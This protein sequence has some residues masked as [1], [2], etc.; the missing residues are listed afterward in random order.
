MK[1]SF[2][3]TNIT[4]KA[5]ENKIRTAFETD[6]FSARALC[7]DSKVLDR[8]SSEYVLDWFNNR[9]EK[10]PDS[11]QAAAIGSMNKNVEIVA[12]AGSGKTTA[13]VGRANF[14]INHCNVEPESI[15][16]LAFNREAVRTM[17]ERMEELSPDKSAIPHI[18]TFHSL[19]LSVVTS[20]AEAGKAVNDH[21]IV[22][23]DDE[24]SKIFDERDEKKALSQ[25]IQK[26]IFN[27]IS[28]D[29]E[30]AFL[31]RTLMEEY[32]KGTWRVIDKYGYNLPVADQEAFLRASDHLT[33]GGEEVMSR[34][35]KLV[36][37][38]L[39]EHDKKYV[40]WFSSLFL[41]SNQKRL[42]EIRLVDSNWSDKAVQKQVQKKC[43][44]LRPKDFEEG[45]DNIRMLI[46]N[47][48]RSLGMDFYK[49]PD[50]IIWE[51]IRQR[52]I[53]K[54]SEAMLTFVGRCRKLVWSPDELAE[55]ISC[56]KSLISMEDQFLKLALVVYREYVEYLRKN[57]MEDFDGIMKNAADIVAMGHY[58]FGDNGDLR[59]FKHI[60]IDEY[61]DFSPLF[62]RFITEIQKKCPSA[63]L[64]CVGDN[65]QAINS[66]AGSDLQFFT[67]F[68]D[69]YE[70]SKIYDM[71]INYR[72]AKKIVD[73]GN[74]LIAHNKTAP[75]KANRDD[76]GV[77]KIGV[78]DD[79]SSTPE[80]IE[81]VLKGKAYL[82][83]LPALRIIQHALNTGQ[84]VV[85]LFRTRGLLDKG[86]LKHLRAFFPDEDREKI[87]A[88]TVH[89][90]KGGQE[91]VVIVM[92]AL[93]RKYPLIHPTW[94]FY[95]IF[96]D[97]KRN[98]IIKDGLLGVVG[99][100]TLSNLRLSEK[101]L[102]YVAI[103]RAKNEMFILTRKDNESEFLLDS[104]I[105][106]HTEILDWYD[107]VDTKGRLLFTIKI[108]NLE[109]R[110]NST[111]MVKNLLLK[112]KYRWNS[113]EKC[114]HKSFYLNHVD[115][116]VDEIP[117]FEEEWYK[118]A[119]YIKIDICNVTENEIYKLWKM[120]GELYRR[121]D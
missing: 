5:S 89:K 100:V 56:H 116:D 63:S 79:F 34:R 53:N 38:T 90:Y 60:L 22:D 41:V 75:A 104:N 39:F 102:F 86:Y 91:D 114:W 67:S 37:D 27:L 103:S 36:A 18:R 40:N 107:Y 50:D 15:L 52:S 54:C 10:T 13:I 58:S 71:T 113:R 44:A 119:D 117:V 88:T 42:A 110:V 6:Y 29:E 77:V 121:E 73:T 33:L 35:M 87:S 76:E 105:Y 78:L 14:L 26:I 24:E 17:R 43:L 66:F 4:N 120:G 98:I 85:L 74:L 81:M 111:G 83:D 82:D 101:R 9:N 16:M 19:A 23:I 106:D 68:E 11:D 99:D 80:E 97:D 69:R 7:A 96:D 1:D 45:P 109:P 115:E 72:S 12:R 28:E 84:K 32:F 2:R 62:D 108:S 30:I 57:H 46:G 3:L 21:I 61:Q 93:K 64:F 70:D 8:L 65:W 48:V 92:D 49:L 31:F 112:D 20:A 118:E 51:K 47:F 94:V 25:I 59:K 95:R 55:R